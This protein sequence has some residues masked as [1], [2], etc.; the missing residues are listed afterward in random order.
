MQVAVV[1]PNMAVRF[2]VR[3]DLA[4]TVA[5]VTATELLTIVPT[6]SLALEVLLV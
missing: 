4:A 1:V 6:T 5:V 2:R 3:L